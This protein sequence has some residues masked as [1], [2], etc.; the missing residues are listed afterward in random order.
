MNFARKQ[1]S[2]INFTLIELLVVI[3][4]IAILASMLLPA[5]NKAR[6]KARSISC[7]AQLK[8]FGTVNTMYINDYEGYPI[9]QGDINNPDKNWT[10]KRY[11]PELMLSYLGMHSIW[12]GPRG[13]SNPRV[14]GKPNIFT[15]PEAAIGYRDASLLNKRGTKWGWNWSYGQPMIGYGWNERLRKGGQWSPVKE[16]SLKNPAECFIF[17]DANGFE[18]DG[19]VLADLAP[20]ATA[21]VAYRHN[22][23]ANI[24]Y[25][26]SH[27]DSSKNVKKHNPAL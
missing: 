12:T 8:Q 23:W 1:T 10:G 6:G 16:N 4:I 17:T 2:V 25:M 5:L 9:L 11:W 27:V 21:Y 3:A 24:V 13:A 26:D 7:K 20:V 15:C 18:L 14:S 22:A 19:N